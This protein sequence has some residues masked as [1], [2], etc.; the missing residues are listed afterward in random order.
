MDH[1]QCWAGLAWEHKMLLLR[2]SEG[3]KIG[4]LIFF[5]N[6]FALILLLLYR[7]RNFSLI[8]CEVAHDS[9]QT[10]YTLFA[11]FLRVMASKLVQYWCYCWNQWNLLCFQSKMDMRNEE[12]IYIINMKI[13]GNFLLILNLCKVS[14]C[15]HCSTKELDVQLTFSSYNKN[16]K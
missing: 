6:Y 16:V 12:Y 13:Y 15:L 9:I 11:V 1:F 8:G 5:G 3:N 14:K 2:A 10:F 7:N 4:Q